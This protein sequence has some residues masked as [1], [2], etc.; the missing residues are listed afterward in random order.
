MNTTC[1]DP[2]KIIH[3]HHL[4]Q[5]PVHEFIKVFLC[6]FLHSGSTSFFLSNNPLEKHLNTNNTVVVT[7]QFCS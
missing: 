4:D 7:F 3:L 5:A 2:S 1:L 6:Y